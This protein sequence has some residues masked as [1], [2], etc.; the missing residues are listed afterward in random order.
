MF[1]KGDIVQNVVYPEFGEGMIVS[2]T[3]ENRNHHERPVEVKWGAVDYRS[4]VTC[5][6]LDG[7]Q[8]KEVRIRK[9]TKLD[10]AL[11]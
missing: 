4:G 1:K 3:G 8:G 9:L 7:K 2:I 10:K 5:Y 11:K 6:T